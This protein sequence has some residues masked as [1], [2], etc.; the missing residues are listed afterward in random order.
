MKQLKI[1]FGVLTVITFGSGIYMKQKSV[2]N[3]NLI[4]RQEQLDYARS[5]MAIGNGMLGIFLGLF[6]AEY[7]LKN[8]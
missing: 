1:A 6:L 8:K 5:L 4:E 3:P 2:A 7:Q